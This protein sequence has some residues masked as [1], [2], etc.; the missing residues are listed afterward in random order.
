MY[1]C[2]LNKLIDIINKEDKLH[3]ND[4]IDLARI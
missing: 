4:F 1:I 2:R 3:I